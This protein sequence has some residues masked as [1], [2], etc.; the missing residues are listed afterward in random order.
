MTGSLARLLRRVAKRLDRLGET[1][2][3]ADHL[4]S[5]NSTAEIEP[6]NI[7]R[8][9]QAKLTAGADSTVTGHVPKSI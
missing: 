9:P 2:V 6:L 1:A 3:R 8:C 7:R 4:A 5:V